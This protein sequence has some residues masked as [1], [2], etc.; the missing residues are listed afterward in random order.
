MGLSIDLRWVVLLVVCVVG[1]GWKMSEY[2]A[3]S[4]VPDYTCTI[5][6]TES[7]PM[8][9]YPAGST[10]LIYPGGKTR[11]QESDY[12][13]AFI[14]RPGYTDK[15]MLYVQGGGACWDKNSYEN[16]YCAKTP[17]LQDANGVFVDP[18][19]GPFTQVVALYCSGDL[20]IGNVTV[21]YRDAAGQRVQQRGVENML[22][23]VK[24]TTEQIKTSPSSPAYL[25]STLTEMVLM[26]VSAGAVAVPIWSDYVFRHIPSTL[27]ATVGDSYVLFMPQSIEGELLRDTAGFCET[28]VLLPVEFED[29]C[30]AGTLRIAD[31]NIHNM[32]MRPRV[33]FSNIQAKLDS[34]QAFYYNAVLMSMGIPPIQASAYYA[35]SVTVIEELNQEPNYLIFMIDSNSHG[36]TYT[37]RYPTADQ[38][39]DTGASNNPGVGT[40]LRE[41]VA[42]LPLAEGE[43]IHSL[44]GGASCPESVMTKSYTASARES[45]TCFQMKSWVSPS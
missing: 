38:Y 8:H 21:K 18:H 42:Q 19:F 12:P 15:L 28:S 27:Y 11:C 2:T 1:Y 6:P 30:W 43:T 37:P 5:T 22:A 17:L 7:C 24:W 26:G 34:T 36:Y 14:V 39:S 33:A 44:C 10:V 23:V 29:E 40:P 31:L 4:T 45:V 25:N 9:N 16:D 3:G 20:F 35:R 13:Y 41:W 32:R